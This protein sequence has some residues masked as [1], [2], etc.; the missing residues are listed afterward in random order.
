[1]LFVCLKGSGIAAVLPDGHVD[2]CR[3]P[4]GLCLPLHELPV[5]KGK[6]SKGVEECPNQNTQGAAT[7]FECL[8]TGSCGANHIITLV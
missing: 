2:I 7:G 6:D 5:R 3:D 4:R 8:W 1:M